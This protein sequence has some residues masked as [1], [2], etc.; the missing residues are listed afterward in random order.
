LEQTETT[1]EDGSAHY[2]FQPGGVSVTD[3]QTVF[4]WTLAC[5]LITWNVS[6]AADLADLRATRVAMVDQL[7][8]RADCMAW[9]D[10]EDPAA[11]GLKFSGGRYA[12]SG[13]SIR[14]CEYRRCE[15]QSC[16]QVGRTS[17]HEILLVFN[18]IRQSRRGSRFI[19]AET[20]LL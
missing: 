8:S 3:P 17:S 4:V 12:V 15:K 19:R 9:Y 6:H 16:R 14:D 1:A 18:G 13:P 5:A 11:Q 7:R 2:R 20:R 10:F